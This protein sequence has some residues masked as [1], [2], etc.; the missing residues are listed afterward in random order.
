MSGLVPSGDM[1]G[2]DVV[3]I[4]NPVS[5]G[6]K[7]KRCL[8][9]V[10]P[11][12]EAAFESFEARPTEGPGHATILCRAALEKGASLI[13]AFGGDGTTNEVLAGFV[14]ED[15]ENCFPGAEI[16]IIATGTGSDFVRHLGP[17]SLEQQVQAVI[18]GPG[19]AIDYG[20]AQM[21]SSDGQP[22]TRPFLNEASVGVSGLVSKHV[23]RAPRMFGPAASYVWSSVRSLSEHRDKGVTMLLE[24][25]VP[26]RLP[27]TLAVFANGQYFGGGMWIAPEARCDDGWLD[28]LYTGGTGKAHFVTLLAR[29]FNGS[30]VRSSGV[31]SARSRT[32]RMV[33]DD[34][35][36]VVLIALDGE[37]PGRLPATFHIVHQ[38]IRVRAHGLPAR[39]PASTG[40]FAPVGDP[41]EE[42]APV[43]IARLL[44]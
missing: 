29:V 34:D 11:L 44:H 3:C 15:G 27:L 1:S 17:A 37:Q 5:G 25:D 19:H 35:R 40:A 32:V 16:G 24:D 9:T 38:G 20:V 39:E 33:P 4:Y 18:D 6:G 13:I 43:R 7:T 14:D 26:I 23:Q 8:A 21:V 41:E 42:P 30:H 2:P 36:D 31:R 22:L 12:L 28:V 10:R